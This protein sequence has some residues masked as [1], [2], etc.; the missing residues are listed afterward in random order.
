MSLIRACL[1]AI[2]VALAAGWI[3]FADPALAGGDAARLPRFADFP[4]ALNSGQSAPLRLSRDDLSFKTRIRHLYEAGRR[5]GPNFAGR[6]SVTDVG[7]GT[8]CTFLLAVDMRTGRTVDFGIPSGEDL[9]VCDDRYIDADG[10]YPGE[11]GKRFYFRPNS[12]LFV[13]TGRMPGNE[14]GARYF[15]ERDGRMIMIRDFHL[16][17]HK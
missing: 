10:G 13:V 17:T 8:E 12:R 4:A 6:Y 14:C 3:G 9:S 2:L 16:D 11:I 15:E 1:P 7:C 5:Y